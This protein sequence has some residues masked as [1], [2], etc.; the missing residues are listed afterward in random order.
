MATL[1]RAPS[2]FYSRYG[3]PTVNALRGRHRRARGRRGGAGVRV[4]HG[5][6]QRGGARRCA[7]PAT[8]SS[9]SASSTPARSCCCSARAPASASTSRSSTAPSPVRSPPRCGRA[10]PCWSSPRRRPT[11]GSTLVDLDERRRHRRARSRSSTPRSPRPLGAAAARPRRRPRGALGHEGHRRPQRRHARRGRRQRRS[12]ISWLWSFAVL[13]GA[14]RLAVRRPERPARHL[15]T[16]AVRLR[17]QS[18]TAQ[19]LAE[20]LEDHPTVAGG[21]ATP[22]STSHPQRDLAKRQMALPAARA[23]L[24]GRRRL[25]AGR[26]FVESAASWRSWP[27]RSAGPRRS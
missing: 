5:R 6:G 16:L 23:H 17:Q 11:R 18:E 15:R 12:S 27:R 22:A 10:R 24:R 25:E 2:R 1:D 8:T 26:T 3:N 21:A 20:V 4:G 14:T 13:Q 7:R 9:P 19:R